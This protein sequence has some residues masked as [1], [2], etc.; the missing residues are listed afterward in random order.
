MKANA[1]FTY[2]NG[3]HVIF[4]IGVRN[5]LQ[6]QL[7]FWI[8]NRNGFRYT[9]EA[10]EILNITGF[11]QTSVSVES[12]WKGKF[13]LQRSPEIFPLITSNRSVQHD[14]RHWIAQY[15]NSNTHRQPSVIKS[16]KPALPPKPVF[17]TKKEQSVQEKV[18][19]SQVQPN[20]EVN[21]SDL[22]Q[23]KYEKKLQEYKQV[24]KGKR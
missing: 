4:Q 17:A 9:V 19:E 13:N 24:H 22:L 18:D 6:K 14:P 3:K 12:I 15:V 21:E 7:E 11:H 8:Q 2:Q 10:F 1:S 16:A 20:D 23:Q 5:F